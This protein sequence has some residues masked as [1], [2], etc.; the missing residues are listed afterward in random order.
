MPGTE[1]SMRD[2]KFIKIY[3]LPLKKK[4]NVKLRKKEEVSKSAPIQGNGCQVL[5]VLY[6]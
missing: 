3:S 5:A 6:V 2:K 4:T 1:L